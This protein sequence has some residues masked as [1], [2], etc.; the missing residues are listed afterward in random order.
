[1]PGTGP[2]LQ[3]ALGNNKKHS[4]CPHGRGVI[5]ERRLDIIKMSLVDPFC[6]NIEQLA[7]RALSWHT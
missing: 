3:D 1:M 7:G 2:A 4:T 6:S 5:K